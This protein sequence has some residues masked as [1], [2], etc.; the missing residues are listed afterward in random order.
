MSVI[1]LVLGMYV[2]CGSKE[3]VV[4]IET[5][6]A[7]G[8][9]IVTLNENS[10]A[11]NNKIV[12]N[13]SN[14][15]E[16]KE[17]LKFLKEDFDELKNLEYPEKCN[18]THVFIVKSYETLVSGIEELLNDNQTAFEIHIEESK[19][20]LLQSANEFTKVKNEK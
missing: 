3:E 10:I 2:G 6:E 7:Y 15:K 13:M 17:C 12:E 19:N 1:F 18:D 4:K 20:Y 5:I 16:I 8:N 14:K 11:I 9:Y